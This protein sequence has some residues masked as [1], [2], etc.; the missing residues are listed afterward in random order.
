MERSKAQLT[1]IQYEARPAVKAGIAA[2]KR[3]WVAAHL[4]Q[5]LLRQK[6]YRA[7]PR[8]QAVI[9]AQRSRYRL[10]CRHEIAMRQKRWTQLPAVKKQLAEYHHAYHKRHRLKEKRYF[11]AYK[12]SH[13][14][15]C[16][17]YNAKRKQQIAAGPPG[18]AAI[19]RQFYIMAAR[20]TKCTGF[21]WEVDHII[22]L[23]RG[24]AHHENNLQVITKAANSRKRDKLP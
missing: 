13:L 22:P 24:G 17:H 9:K 2:Q 10:R 11:R 6:A 15:Q 16:A 19:I 4:P 12:K 5:V 1:R 23:S 8:G 7:S 20:L 21:P 3:A 18:S 14:P